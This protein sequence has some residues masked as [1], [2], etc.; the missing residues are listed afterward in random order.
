MTTLQQ[1]DYI[2][3]DL[4][5]Q[6]EQ[7]RRNASR[8]KKI[9]T[10]YRAKT[11][12]YEIDAKINQIKKVHAAYKATPSYKNKDFD[13]WVNAQKQYIKECKEIYAR[14]KEYENVVGYK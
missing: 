5:E 10:D 14:I 8:Y 4:I 2:V 7:I 6:L 3:P 9:D 1:L 12:M 13:N 11:L